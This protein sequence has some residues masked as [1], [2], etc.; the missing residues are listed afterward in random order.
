LV[1]RFGGDVLM[2]DLR[3]KI[4]RVRVVTRAGDAPRGA[5][6]GFAMTDDTD[7]I[8][9]TVTWIGQTSVAVVFSKGQAL[10]MAQKMS[11]AS[12]LFLCVNLPKA[13]LCRSVGECNRFFDED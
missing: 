7:E 4:A 13:A 10:T 5:L 3:H 8:A 6:L 2:P 9:A 11:G 1:A 12:P